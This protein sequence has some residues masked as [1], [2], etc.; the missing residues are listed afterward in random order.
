MPTRLQVLSEGER[1]QVHERTLKLLSTTGVRV[2]SPRARKH[3]AEGGAVVDD[4]D[5]RVR[6]PRRLI[7]TC[8][9]AAPRTLTLGG[10]RPG[11]SMRMNAGEC[12]LGAD[13]SGV[14]VVDPESQRWRPGS[15]DDW[16][17]AT[18]LI[19]A[20]DEVG[21]YW[22]MVEPGLPLETAPGALRYWR[23]V[24]T[25]YSKHVQDSPG[26]A[27]ETH[28]LLEVLEVVFG[29]RETVRRLHPFS[30]LFCPLSPLVIEGPLIDAYL[31]TAGWDIP[32]AVMPMPLMGATAPAS[33]IST[34]TLAN[35]EVLAVLCL[36][37]SALPGTP[38]LYAP[39]PAVVNPHS[40]R[41]GGGEIE[42]ALL[43]A[44]ATE[45]A[46]FYQ[47]PAECSTGGS[48]EPSIGVRSGLERALNWSLPC[49]AW[50]DILIGPGLLAGSTVLSLEQLLI[51]V[52]IFRRLAR[53]RRGIESDERHWLDELIACVGP[54]GNFLS[55]PST[56]E[57]LHR[58]EWYRP[59]L[60]RGLSYERWLADGQPGLLDEA[61]QQLGQILATHSP[62]PL[63]EEVLRELHHLEARAREMSTAGH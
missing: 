54:G 47:L 24:F 30:H 43:G 50:P 41:F 19:D 4:T 21:V 6:F 53:L 34:L 59:K 57:A 27:E 61:R 35:A 25:N 63:E 48:D 42:H 32:I 20:L 7:E 17:A 2:E 33:L 18:R 14:H 39:V 31:E 46:R 38:F 12:W 11:W 29:E 44:A 36:V 10:R 26:S 55:Q 45:M 49:L 56:R 52:E 58:G 60:G 28:W 37:Q 62:L 13:G 16:I 40:W 51:D 22:C 5:G 23:E 15:L 8:L 1:V 9:S 3:L